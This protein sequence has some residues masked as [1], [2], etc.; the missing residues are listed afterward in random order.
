M[1]EVVPTD[2]PA[3]LARGTYA[4]YETPTG[5]RVLAYR[6]EGEEQSGQFVIPGAAIRIL[7]RIQSGEE[8]K[9]LDIVRAMMGR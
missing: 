9:P 8:L 1:T 5:D 6:P 3:P 2:V 4:I 7:E